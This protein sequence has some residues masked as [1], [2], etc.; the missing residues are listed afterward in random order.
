MFNSACSCNMVRN[1]GFSFQLLYRV[2]FFFFCLSFACFYRGDGDSGHITRKINIELERFDEQLKNRPT[3][4]KV[5][6]EHDK[7]I[8]DSIKNF[9]Q[10]DVDKTV[11]KL[12]LAKM[13]GEI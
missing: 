9:E 6:S 4:R 8:P 2:V 10:V 7:W 3:K 11:K 12:D 13:R 5:L 1:R